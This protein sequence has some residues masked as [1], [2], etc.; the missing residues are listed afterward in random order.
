MTAESR[1]AILIVLRKN[2]GSVD[3]AQHANFS[4]VPFNQKW[5]HDQTE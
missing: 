2:L 1:P 4:P 3:P 5:S